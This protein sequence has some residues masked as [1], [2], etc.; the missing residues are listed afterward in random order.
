[1]RR[2][3]AEN[4]PMN[5]AYQIPSYIKEYRNTLFLTQNLDTDSDF[6]SLPYTSNPIAVSGV[7]FN[8]AVEKN[9]V[10]KIIQRVSETSDYDE[11]KTAIDS[12]GVKYQKLFLENALDST[13]MTEKVNMAL[14]YFKGLYSPE[15]DYYRI[16]D[17]SFEK[18]D[19]KWV[20][21]PIRITRTVIDAPN[22]YGISGEFNPRENAFWIRIIKEKD[23]D[24]RKNLPGK[25]CKNYSEEDLAYLCANVGVPYNTETTENLSKEKVWDLLASYK[26]FRSMFKETDPVEKLRAGY[27][28]IALLE[29]KKP[30]MCKLIFDFLK[31]K[32][33]LD[34]NS[35]RPKGYRGTIKKGL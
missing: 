9:V 23:R 14:K 26:K 12:L 20:D 13:V 22:P 4:I 2:I 33:L 11:F 1:V 10:D 16:G 15:K 28:F 7:S 8:M 17:L 31:S 29:G 6:F 5:N 25:E 18:K 3:V 19:G 35:N 30:A 27:F 21:A 34:E 32:G 24:A